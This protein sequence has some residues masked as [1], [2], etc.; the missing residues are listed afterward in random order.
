VTEQLDLL[1]GTLDLLI[2]E[3]LGIGSQS[4]LGNCPACP[5]GVAGCAA[6]RPR[7]FISS[8]ASA[9]KEG[10]DFVGVAIDREQPEGEILR[11]HALWPLSTGKRTV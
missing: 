4:R 1:Q 2:F 10:P 6:G 8:T 9:G 11:T 5:A 7:I 3:N